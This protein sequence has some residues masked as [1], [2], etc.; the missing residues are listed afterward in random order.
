MSTKDKDVPVTVEAAK[1]TPT[2]TPVTALTPLDAKGRPIEPRPSTPVPDLATAR[3]QLRRFIL[4]DSGG[5]VVG[6]ADDLRDAQPMADDVALGLYPHALANDPNVVEKQAVPDLAH[7]HAPAFEVHG[8]AVYERVSLHAPR[9]FTKAELEEKTPEGPSVVDLKRKRA[10]LVVDRAAAEVADVLTA[11]KVAKSGTPSTAKAV[12]QPTRA[13]REAELQ[14]LSAEKVKDL[15]DKAGVP[16]STKA[17]AI[18]N[19]LDAEF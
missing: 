19:L 1:T 4:L 14:E 2:G 11:E 13:E 7:D 6:H 18:A 8:V 17:E 5:K 10:K 9:A 16:A 12:K 15:A 3:R